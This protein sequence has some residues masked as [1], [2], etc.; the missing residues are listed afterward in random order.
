M[1]KPHRHGWSALVSQTMVRSDPVVY[2]SLDIEGSLQS[3]HDL[4][5]VILSSTIGRRTTSEG[6]IKRLNMIGM[7]LMS[8]TDG[9]EGM[10]WLGPISPGPPLRPLDFP[11]D[12]QPFAPHLA[13]WEISRSHLG[14]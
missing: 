4:G 13:K 9:S 11:G 12:F 1:D 3:L 2:Q 14:R 8:W 10:L 6:T 5:I 7:N